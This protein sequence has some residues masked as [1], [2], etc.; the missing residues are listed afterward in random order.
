MSC[1]RASLPRRLLIVQRNADVGRALAR[2]FAPFVAEV[3]ATTSPADAESWLQ[4][5]SP[6][7]TDV[8]CGVVFGPGEAPGTDWIRRYRAATPLGTL[9]IASAAPPEHC[10]AADL[11]VAQP[12]DP[13]IILDFLYAAALGAPA[14]R[15]AA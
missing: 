7:P 15:G 9:V 10:D 14:A 4:A 6:L 5:A 1:A 11:I 12:I 2:F 13:R 8:I 3:E